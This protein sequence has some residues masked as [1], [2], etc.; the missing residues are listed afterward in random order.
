MLC[1]YNG[2]VQPSENE[3]GLSLCIN[4]ELFSNI[5]LNEKESRHL[6][7]TAGYHLNKVRKHCNTKYYL[8]MDTCQTNIK[9]AMGIFSTKF[10]VIT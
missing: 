6:S 5:K 10:T 7:A 4:Q 9:I 2:M 8:E 1:P 3:W